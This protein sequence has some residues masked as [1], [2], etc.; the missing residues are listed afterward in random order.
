MPKFLL[1]VRHTPSRRIT[2]SCKLTHNPVC[3]ELSL[4][5]IDAGKSKFLCW[6]V[7]GVVA[8]QCKGTIDVNV[9]Q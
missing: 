3:I 4:V 2:L 6:D 5:L 7:D 9:K 8:Y 1:G